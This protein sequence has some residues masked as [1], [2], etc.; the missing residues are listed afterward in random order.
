MIRIKNK[1]ICSLNTLML[2]FSQVNSW[3]AGGAQRLRVPIISGQPLVPD[4][5]NASVGKQS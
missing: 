3:K 1:D 2:V 4:L 5:G